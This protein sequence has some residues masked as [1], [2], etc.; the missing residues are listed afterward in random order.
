MN[1]LMLI[2]WGWSST[3]YLRHEGDEELLKGLRRGRGRRH[4]LVITARVSN[5]WFRSSTEYLRHERIE[6]I[7]EGMR[8]GDGRR[9]KLVIT[10]RVTKSRGGASG[11]ISGQRG[12]PSQGAPARLPS[13]D[14]VAGRAPH[15][16]G[17]IGE[18]ETRLVG[19]VGVSGVVGGG[20][21]GSSAERLHIDGRGTYRIYMCTRI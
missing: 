20:P 1:T 21:R 15:S 4:W 16:N 18:G 19:E 14:A 2:I 5:R 3:E 8:R 12:P 6:E 10:A 9:Q 7:F 11:K 13:V 17:R